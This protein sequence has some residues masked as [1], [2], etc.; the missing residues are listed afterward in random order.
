[1]D[2]GAPK[3]ACPIHKNTFK[4]EDG[5]GISNKGFN[6]STFEAPIILIALRDPCLEALCCPEGLGPL[7]RSHIWLGPG[8]D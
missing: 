4:L 6:L 5:K 8:E 7:D 1:M 2:K 3:V